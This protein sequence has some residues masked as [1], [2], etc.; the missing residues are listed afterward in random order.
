[1][2]ASSSLRLMGILVFQETSGM[3]GFGP[4]VYGVR[5]HPIWLGFTGLASL[6]LI[7]GYL[8]HRSTPSPT[9]DEAPPV[10]V[11]WSFQQSDYGAIISSPLVAGN[12]IYVGAI[13]DQGLSTSGV[14]YCLDRETG[15]K[16]W[17]FDDDGAMQHMYSSPC[18]AGGLLYIGEGMHAN[19]VCKLYCLEAATGHKRW[20]FE[21]AGHIESSPCV[22]DGQVFFG[23]GDDGIFCL[24]AVTGQERW[25]FHGPFHVDTSACVV[26]GRLYAGSGLSRK[27]KKT[28]IFCL[29]AGD[30]TEVWRQPTALPVWGS[31]AV[32]RDQ[33]FF[34]LGNGRLIRDVVPPEKPAGAVLCVEAA[35][36][37]IQWCCHVPNG[38]LAEPVVDGQRLYFGARDGYCYAVDRRDGRQCWRV[39]LG[40]PVVTRP[41]LLDGNLFVVASGGRVVRLDPGTGRVHWTFDLAAVTQTR[42]QMFSSPAVWRT[43][44]ARA[45][46]H[47]LYFGAEL[48][49]PSANSFAL[50]YC[51]QD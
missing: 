34:G 42:P 29:N 6:G 24:D 3:L 49:V 26:G 1:M 15:H 45:A 47:R 13:R 2:P 22:A 18:L 32:D 35:T 25:H 21:T 19:H 8:I 46:H 27:Y 38:V 48:R 30:G 41:A 14:V 28:E 11:V 39:D 37:R 12:R 31:P 10:Q 33:V 43:D 7:A 50:L 36:G 17:E 51:L 40:S 23:S 4:L 5:R 9:G 20:D 16:V 44:G